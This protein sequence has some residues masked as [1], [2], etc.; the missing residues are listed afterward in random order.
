MSSCTIF[1]RHV[2]PSVCIEE[3]KSRAVHA[4]LDI[5][6]LV[7]EKPGDKFCGLILGTHNFIR[8]KGREDTVRPVL[9]FVAS[10][11]VIV[12]VPNAA[13]GS[14]SSS[15]ERFAALIDGFDA[16]FFDGNTMLD[17]TGKDLLA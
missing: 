5:H 14:V 12:G 9:A 3:L 2:S 7:R 17:R 4:R 8:K 16:V 13:E 1:I 10:T 6:P 11:S 15:M